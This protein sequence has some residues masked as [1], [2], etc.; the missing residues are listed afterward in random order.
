MPDRVQQVGLAEARLPVD[1]QGVV[2]LGRRLGDGDR[3]RVREAVGGADDEGVEEVLRVQPRGRLAGAGAPARAARPA[4]RG[5]RWARAAG[6]GPS[7]RCT[8]GWPL[9]G[10]AAAAALLVV[11]ARGRSA[12]VSYGGCASLGSRCCCDG[13][14]GRG[15]AYGSR[16]GK[17][18]RRLLL[19][20]V[21]VLLGGC[22]AR[23]RAAVALLLVVRV[24]GAGGG[25]LGR[26]GSCRGTAG[27]RGRDGRLVAAVTRRGLSCCAGSDGAAGC[28]LWC[29]V[30]T[31]GAAVARRRG[32]AG[33]VVDGDRDPDRA[34]ALAAE[35]LADQRGQAAF[36]DALARIRWGRRA[37]RC[38]RP[39]RAAGSA[40][41]S[42]WSLASMPCWPSAEELLQHSWPHCGKIGRYISHRARSLTR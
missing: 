3:R 31:R 15:E 13:V 20:A 2:R 37:G 19:P 8:G 10:H 30:R 39:A 16:S 25:Q 34:A 9:G 33:G 14:S 35:G 21:V 7:Q 28:E 23:R 1:E 4:G 42:C 5:R 18:P 38:R 27:C 26:P 22:A 41:S 12:A 29:R 17:P 6:A 40:R 36:E 24:G 32:L 11:L